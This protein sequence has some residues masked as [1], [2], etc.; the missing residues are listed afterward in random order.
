MPERCGP[1]T[2]RREDCPDRAEAAARVE[3]DSCRVHKTKTG[4]RPVLVLAEAGGFEPP[5]PLRVYLIS[6]QA[7]STTLARFQFSRFYHAVT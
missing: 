1:S 2:D 7:H 6:S 4:L 3:G 5:I